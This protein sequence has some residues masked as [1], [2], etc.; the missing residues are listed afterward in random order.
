[1]TWDRIKSSLDIG[2]IDG[3]FMKEPL[4][5]SSLPRFKQ[6]VLLSIPFSFGSG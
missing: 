1:M 4:K 2:C 5:F 6:D 3:S